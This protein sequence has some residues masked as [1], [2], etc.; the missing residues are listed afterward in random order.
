MIE[1]LIKKIFGDPSAKR[2]QEISKEISLI[3]EAEK[4]FEQ[5]TLDDVKKQTAEFKGLFT[6]LDFKNE[7]DSQKIKEILSTIQSD[8][9]ALHKRACQLLL[10]QKFI[11][12]DEREI[13]WNMIPYDVQLIGGLAIHLGSISEMK[14]GEGKTLVATLPAYL[15]ALTGNT[16]H[17]V[18][19][20]DYLAQRDSEEMGILYQALGLTVGVIHNSQAR[21]PK[22]AAYDSDVV[23]ATN[24]ELGFDYLRDN[25]VRD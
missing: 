12:S 8:A 20:N 9:F 5:F 25:M 16:I 7:E 19:V 13:T 15:N 22:K 6:D 10:G 11:L 17:V 21:E 3:H 1:E 18:T 2:V 14:T 4:K 23:Y 24:N